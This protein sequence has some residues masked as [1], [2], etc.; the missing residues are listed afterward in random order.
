MHHIES[1]GYVAKGLDFHKFYF[2]LPGD[3]PAV[4]PNVTLADVHV[5]LLTGGVLQCVAA[6]G[7]ALQC[8][9]VKP[10]AVKH[11]TT[12]AHVHVR[13]LPEVHAGMLQCAAVV[14]CGVL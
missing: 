9:A 13:L 12:L 4:K 7:S 1:V 11:K 10:P 2:D 14:C 5:R 6:R 8:V 3:P